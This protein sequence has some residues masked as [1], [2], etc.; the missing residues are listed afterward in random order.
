MLFLNRIYL[1]ITASKENILHFKIY[2]T[3]TNTDLIIEFSEGIE[4][5]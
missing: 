2:E 5:K 3:N 4:K 1:I